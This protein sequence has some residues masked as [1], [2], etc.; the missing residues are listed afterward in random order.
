MAGRAAQLADQFDQANQELIQAV[1]QCS[2]GQW[3]ATCPAEGWS[4]A[5]AAH[6][7]AVSHEA[8]AGVALIAAN[9][10][11]A[12]P[13][14]VEMLN[15]GNAEHAQQFANCS[16]AETVALLRSGGAT[17]SEMVR[18][19]SDEQLGRAT[20][21]VGNTMTAEQIIEGILIGHV[22]E[23]LQSMRAAAPA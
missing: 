7:V 17:A 3:K 8:I 4:V 14:T 23:H 15:Q 12:P 2:D 10:Q 20:Q 9:A 21:L 6:H 13:F 16:K 19:L 5:V 1:E 11:P 18:G 22:H